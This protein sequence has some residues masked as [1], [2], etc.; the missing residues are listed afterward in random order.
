[1]KSISCIIPA[2]NESQ[3]IRATL[4]VAVSLLGVHLSE[5]IVVDDAS[6][7]QTKTIITQFPQVRLIAHEANEGKSKS[8]ADAISVSTGEYMFL[9]DADLKFLNA[10]H[11]IDMLTPIQDSVSDVSIS[12]RKNAWP[13]FPFRSIDYLS[14]ERILPK[15]VLVPAL[16][17]MAKLPSYGLEVF[18]NRII[19]AKQL[20]IK[21]V[22]WQDV[23]NDFNQHKHGWWKGAVIIARIWLNVLST[24]SIIELY[25]QNIHLRKLIVH[26]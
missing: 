21:V 26:E 10:Q 13:L 16:M 12:Y 3:R 11:L 25:A 20:K 8:V 23:E 6:T 14:G 2:Y 19:I 24:A 15:V 1:M 17:Q 22:R 4:E 18:L 5:I 9:L 7:D